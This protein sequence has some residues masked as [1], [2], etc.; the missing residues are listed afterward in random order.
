MAQPVQRRSNC[1]LPA[2]VRQSGLLI[3]NSLA[4]HRFTGGALAAHGTTDLQNLSGVYQFPCHQRR[5]HSLLHHHWQ[6][7]GLCAGAGTV[8][9]EVRQHFGVRATYCAC[10]RRN[11]LCRHTMVGLVG[12]WPCACSSFWLA[13]LAS[14][15]S[16]HW[17]MATFCSGSFP[18]A[19]CHPLS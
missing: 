11:K 7:G 8:Q 13:P 16:A 5:L 17:A 19:Y 6:H 15:S 2:I 14:T 4:F 10:D 1:D 9:T 12:R 18:S 3:Y